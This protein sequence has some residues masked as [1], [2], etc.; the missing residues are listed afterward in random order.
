MAR[1]KVNGV[2]RDLDIEPEMP[3]LWALR[4]ELGMTGT[5]FG[6]GIASCGAC[7]V[8]V[9]GSAVRSCVTAVSTVEGQEITT[10]EGL[11]NVAVGVNP[12][13]PDLAA[14]QQAW[15]DHQVPQC[16][17]C[18]SGM[19]MAVSSLLARN[20]NPTNAEIDSNITNVC[21][22]GSYPRVRSAIR[23]LANV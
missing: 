9:N 14:V 2:E 10:I 4:D 3:L 15:I 5:K 11:A 8:H 7:T 6:C 22:C 21:R 1:F 13:A 18:Q 16:G 17:Y 20:P 19:I 12:S 23:S